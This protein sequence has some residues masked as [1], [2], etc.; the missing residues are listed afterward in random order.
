MALVPLA[1]RHRNP[2]RQ[3]VHILDPA[4]RGVSPTLSLQLL[5]YLK[6]NDFQIWV[7]SSDVCYSS[8][9]EPKPTRAIKVYFRKTETN[10]I[11]IDTLRAQNLHIET[12]ALPVRLEEMLL[13]LLQRSNYS[14]PDKVA[15]FLDWKVGF[16]PKFT[17]KD[18]QT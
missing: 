2:R 17:T 18:V 12:L 1:L 15:Q 5:P 14:L 10:N 9:A 16:L 7:F 11:D 4:I 6:T 8:L 3:K 13:G